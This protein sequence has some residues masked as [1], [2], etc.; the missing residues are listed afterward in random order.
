M[1]LQS[2]KMF[3]AKTSSLVFIATAENRTQSHWSIDYYVTIVYASFRPFLKRMLGIRRANAIQG[4]QRKEGNKTLILYQV[5]RTW[6]N[7]E[8]R[9]QHQH[10]DHPA[11]CSLF[12]P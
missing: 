11:P 1:F 6:R 8:E 5:E 7:I 10:K 9:L 2:L 4:G 3:P 12:H